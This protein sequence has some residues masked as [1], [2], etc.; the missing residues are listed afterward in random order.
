LA[1]NFDVS[2]AAKQSLHLARIL[3]L[4]ATERRFRNEIW[5][6]FRMDDLNTVERDLPRDVILT[7]FPAWVRLA[8]RRPAEYSRLHFYV[9]NKPRFSQQTPNF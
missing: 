6:S 4:W 2:D 8:K 3:N 7:A 5:K 1:C 9:T